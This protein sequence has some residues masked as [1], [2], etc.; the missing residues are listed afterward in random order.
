MTRHNTEINSAGK[1]LEPLLK[2]QNE[3]FKY[4]A[5]ATNDVIKDWDIVT[6]DIYWGDSFESRYGFQRNAETCNANF[7]L[8]QIHPEDRTRIDQEVY[9]AINNPSL[10]NWE[11][12][13][14]FK[15]ANDD[16]IFVSDR[17]FII[18]DDSGTAIRAIGALNDYTAVK[19]YEQELLALNQQ[20]QKN[21]KELSAS[22]TELERFAYAASHDLQE[23]LRMVTSFLEL[24]K[25]KYAPQ[26]DDTAGKYIAYAVDGASRMKILIMDLLEYSRINTKVF[27]SQA[28]DLEE[29]IARLEN[30]F[31]EDITKYQIKIIKGTL[32][33]LT[34]NYEQ[35][36]Q[37]LQ[38]LISNAIKYRKADQNLVIEIK[39]ELVADE[40]QF[41]IKDNGIGFDMKFSDK[42]FIIFQRLHLKEDYPGTGVGL[43]ICNKIVSRHQG[44]L[45]V[46]SL[47]GKGSTFCFTIPKNL[48]II[49]NEGD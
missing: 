49:T 22:N 29:V 44:K 12:Q 34:A 41:S 43:A 38:N 27:S 11:A 16:Y 10:I 46:E 7:W 30:V 5:K 6:N 40:Y 39:A 4:V 47:P 14:R 19:K 2:L 37:L 17:T 20:L 35:M 45:W 8:A 36:V 15:T 26:L 33:V 3:R 48:K 9:N 13:Y 23:P 32:P 31:A 24:L 25:L 21:A 18:R 1:A 28:V 42:I